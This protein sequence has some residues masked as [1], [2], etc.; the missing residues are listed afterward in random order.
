LIHRTT[1]QVTIRNFRGTSGRRK[2]R[3]RSRR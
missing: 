2:T 3:W 1:N